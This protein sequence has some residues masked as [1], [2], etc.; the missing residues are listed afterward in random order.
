M[1]VEYFINKILRVNYERKIIFTI[2]FKEK[3]KK[4]LYY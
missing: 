3:P 4:T 1:Y 2:D